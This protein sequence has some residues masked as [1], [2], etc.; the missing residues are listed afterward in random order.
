MPIITIFF[1]ELI[2][3]KLYVHF[4]ICYH[5]GAFLNVI[6]FDSFIEYSVGGSFD[7]TLLFFQ[8][9]LR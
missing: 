6:I 5:L 1:V 8:E 2:I 4:L 9:H 7:A 3:L